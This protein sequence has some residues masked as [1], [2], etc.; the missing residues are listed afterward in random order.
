MWGGGDACP[1]CACL[2]GDMP[3]TPSLTQEEYIP[4]ACPCLKLLPWRPVPP[5]PA[6]VIHTAGGAGTVALEVGM[7]GTR[8]AAVPHLP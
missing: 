7:E 2:G 3:V 5:L 6:L 4:S 8:A 1:A